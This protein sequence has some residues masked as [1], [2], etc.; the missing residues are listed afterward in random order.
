MGKDN[1][2][3]LAVVFGLFLAFL[4]NLGIFC[5]LGAAVAYLLNTFAGTT[6][7]WWQAALGLLCVR[8]LVGWF[9]R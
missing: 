7:A 5:L 3:V 1:E 6:I 2:I 9:R 4:I 8:F